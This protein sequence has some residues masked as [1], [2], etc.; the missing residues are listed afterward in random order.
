MESVLEIFKPNLRKLNV[1]AT[2]VE[3]LQRYLHAI[4]L[5]TIYLKQDGLISEYE[6]MNLKNNALES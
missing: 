4:I 3:S 5:K 6:E 1:D 2:E